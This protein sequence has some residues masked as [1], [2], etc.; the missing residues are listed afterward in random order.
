MEEMAT[1]PKA[2]SVERKVRPHKEQALNCPRC[3]STN[4][5]FCYYNNYSLSQPR[6]F[7]KTCRRYWTEG[8]SLRSI[9]V[10][11]G[12]RKN[13]RSSSSSSTYNNN[14]NTNNNNNNN[15]SSS[16]STS[17][18]SSKKLPDL[19]PPHHHHHQQNPKNHNNNN[20]NNFLE[21]QDLNLGFSIHHN[22]NNN[23][24]H[25]DF[26]A[27]T[28]MI[29]APNFENIPSFSGGIRTR[30]VEL[31]T[32]LELQNPNSSSLELLTAGLS[33]SA[34]SSRG[35]NNYAFMPLPVVP[36]SGGAEIHSSPVF[37]SGFPNL[38]EFNIKSSSSS[39]SLNFSL[40][41]GLGSNYGNFQGVQENNGNSS[42]KLLFPFEDLKQD[43][44]SSNTNVNDGEQNGDN[45]NGD[46]STGYWN[47][48][49]GGGSW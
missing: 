46:P 38:A 14:N 8:G 16:T 5:K 43:H 13:K 21:S 20:N 31:G 36:S 41:H 39:S 4:T 37:G 1:C 11:G 19:V 7:C 32:A 47:G 44:D 29:Q 17:S 12:S 40:D 18:N 25:A 9:P 3:N 28:E 49:I 2:S 10:G 26:K 35:F 33:A 24:N 48:V 6:Y 30:E 45:Q 34:A 22:N 27:I 15:S 42:S 23:N